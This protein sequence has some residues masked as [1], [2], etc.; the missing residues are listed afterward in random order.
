MVATVRADEC[1]R[2]GTE[3]LNDLP[4]VIANAALIEPDPLELLGGWA[5]SFE[6]VDASPSAYDS[7]AAGQ[8]RPVVAHQKPLV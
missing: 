4:C 6:C 7:G 8:I 2:A 3:L 1:Y 5:F